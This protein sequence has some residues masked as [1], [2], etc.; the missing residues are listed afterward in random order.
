MNAVLSALP[1]QS[2]LADLLAH[3]GGISADRVRLRPLP[4]TATEEDVLRI[5]REEDRHFELVDGVLVEKVMGLPESKLAMRIGYCL[6][7]YL[8]SNDIGEVAGA[9]GTLRLM[10]GLVRIPDLSYISY[11]RN[12]ECPNPDAPIP[13]LAPDLA[14]E[15]LSEGNTPAE[16]T[17]KLKD[18]FF[19]GVK[20]VWLVDPRKRTV[21]VSRSLD[22]SVLLSEQDELTGEPVLP[23]FRLPV[24][25]IF[26]KTKG[27]EPP[28]R[29]RGKKK[30]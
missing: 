19:C 28:S 25:R 29:G 8:E 22:E 21:Q 26:A 7:E 30:P 5:Q 10:P 18:Y 11:Q 2:S 16:M 6:M 17:Q 9:D 20:L 15:V 13:A 24:A 23:G 12:A 14:V 4:G 3:L 1:A 27:K